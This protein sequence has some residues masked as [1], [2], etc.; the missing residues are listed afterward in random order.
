MGVKLTSVPIPE[1]GPR[2]FIIPQESAILAGVKEDINAAFGGNLNPADETPQGQLAVSMAAAIGFVNDTFLDFTNQVDPA[3]ADGRMQDAI[4]RIYFLERNPAEPTT[5]QAVCSGAVGTR[6]TVG[7]LARTADG[8]TYSCTQEGVIGVSGSI[9][10]PFACTVAG[11]IPCPPGSLSQIFR[12]IAGWESVT[13][14]TEGVLGRNVESRA[15]FEQRRAASVALN[16]VGVLPAIRATVLNVP[17]VLDVYATE[18]PTGA[19]VTVGGVT[20]VAHSL[21]VAVSGGAAADVARAIWRKK[22][23]GCAYNGN[24]TVT[25]VDDNSGYAFPAPS[26][27]VTFETP[28][29]LAIKFA[30]TIADGPTV[31]SDAVAQVRAAIIAA[32]GGNDGGPRARIGATLFASRYYG[33]VAALGSWAAQIVSL[34]VGTTT[35]TANSVAVPINR[36]PTITAGDITVTIV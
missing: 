5:V 3:F 13:N 2:G 34:L 27:A 29:G 19:S 18:N 35:P 30:V 36:V 25:V 12:T 33:P 28:A 15:E 6:I 4:A 22:N 26:Y 8:N 1:F 21:F 31:P 17:N 9:E 7:A 23:P 14:P 11:P 16:A 24:T 10:L 32:F 20:L